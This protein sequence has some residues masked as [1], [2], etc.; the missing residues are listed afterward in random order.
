MKQ[1]LL[2]DALVL[3]VPPVCVDWGLLDEMH[4]LLAC[5]RFAER[6]G[7]KRVLLI[8]SV[9]TWAKTELPEGGRVTEEHHGRRRCAAARRS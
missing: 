9:T 4:A 8:S 3:W 1:L 2:A 7:P 6:A 5:L